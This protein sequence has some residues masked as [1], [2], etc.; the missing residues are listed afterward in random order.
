MERVH[1]LP[2]PIN[3]RPT[4]LTIGVFDGVHLGHQHLIK[5]VVKRA[6]MLDYQS[7]VLTFDPHPDI[8]LHPGREHAYLTNLE[9]RSSLIEALGVDLLIVLPFTH[10]LM[11]WTAQEF[12]IRLCGAVAV[13][14]LWAGPDLAVGKR[15]EGDL[16]RL[17]EIGQTLGYSTHAIDTFLLSGQQVRSTRIRELLRAGDIEAAAVLLDRIFEMRGEVIEGDKRGRTIGF[18]TA[19]IRIDP[20]HILPGDGVYVC[21]AIIH[22]ERCGAVTNIGLR[23]T[24]GGKL[25]R[26][27]SYILDFS[28]DLYGE[29]LRIQFLRRLRGEMKYNSV[30]ELVHQITDDVAVTRAYLAGR[31]VNRI[32]KS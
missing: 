32:S 6:A 30:S 28:G 20:Q 10:E 4:I 17:T 7:A 3:S 8:I 19:N 24:F 12:M 14:E 26:F 9:E 15:R 13:R 18:P 5:T 27:E 31:N 25:R 22:G 16:K 23:P 2:Q 11:A 1:G 21:Y 29:Q